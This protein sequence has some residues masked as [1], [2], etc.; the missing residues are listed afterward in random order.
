MADLG[1]NLQIG[2]FTLQNIAKN[3]GT[4]I[5]PEKSET[6]KLLGQDPVRFK[7]IVDNKCL[8]RNFLLK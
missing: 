1:D 7:F 2:I 4:E 6:I 5:S 8:R 3:F